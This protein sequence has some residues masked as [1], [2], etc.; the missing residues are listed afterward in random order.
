MTPMIDRSLQMAPDMSLVPITHVKLHQKLST[1][2]KSII[3]PHFWTL[4]VNI[5]NI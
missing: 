2:S 1:V 5:L 4:D 3:D